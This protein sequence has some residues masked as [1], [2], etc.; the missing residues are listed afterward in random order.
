MAQMNMIQALNSAMD[1]MMARDPSV[2]VMGEDV[3]YFG[4]VF[5]VTDG[6]QRKYGE[7]RVLDSPIAEG[8]IVATAIGM[9][10]NGL[11]PVAEIQFADYI[12]PAVDQIASEL[13]RI[14]YRS[15]GDFSA[16]VVDARALRRR[17]PRRPD[18]FAES[19]G[20]LRA[21]LRREGGDAV[22]NPYD[23][24]GLLI[25]A[26]EDDDPIIFF[27][28]KRI[29]NGPFD[30]DPNKPAV[31]WS[32]HP[33]GDVPEG[34]YKVPIG[35]CEIVRPGEQVTIVTYGTMVYVCEAAAKKLGH[36]RRDH[37]RAHHVAARHRSDLLFGQED[38]PL[39]GRAR[40]DAFLRLRR[41]T[42]GQ[43]PGRML[44][45]PR[46]AHPARRG[47]GHAIPARLRMGVFS[48]PGTSGAR[49]ARSHGPGMRGVMSRYVFKMPDLGEGTVSAEVVAWHV[50]PGD[51]VQEDQVMCEVMTEKAA[52]EMPAP[53]TGR[54][55]S[56]QGQPGDMVAVGSELVVFDTDATSAAAGDA[57]AA[58]TPPPRRRTETPQRARRN[59]K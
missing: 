3:G 25:A 57:P 8:G 56:I 11:K 44:L 7:H 53:V 15:A 32:T 24:K 42:V 34:H 18:A 19:R 29:Y 4:G 55:L 50:K 31:P 47:L 35:K 21:H 22:S 12:Y 14:R 36:R 6:L 23:A 41:G 27:E 43:H 2:V 10:V 37:R 30:G 45:V 33:K 52:V 49:A 39:R 5:R 46:G 58:K 28:P 13:A 48:R 59:S 9:A 38:R 51:L 16:S 17:H 40:S 26:I 20:D 1:V 54:I